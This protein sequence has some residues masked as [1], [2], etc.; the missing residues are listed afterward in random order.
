M[1]PVLLVALGKLIPVLIVLG[2]GAIPIFLLY[3]IKNHQYRMKELEIEGRRYAGPEQLAAIEQR[4]AAIE[5]ALQLP[6]PPSALAARASM[7]EGP[8]TTR[9]QEQLPG[10]LRER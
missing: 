8:A 2:L 9:D 5:K 6:P 10:R 3:V 7:L 4:L 1:D